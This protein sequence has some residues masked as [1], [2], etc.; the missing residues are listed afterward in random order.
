MDPGRSTSDPFICDL[1]S[2]ILSYITPTRFE[3]MHRSVRLEISIW[4]TDKTAY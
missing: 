3:G 4:G 2:F 1:V